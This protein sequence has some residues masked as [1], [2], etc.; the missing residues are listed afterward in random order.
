[1]A[2]ANNKKPEKSLKEAILDL[3]LNIKIR[4]NEEVFSNINN[5][6]FIDRM[7]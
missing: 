4:T 2:T 5:A 3:Y 6:V 1:M 7:L